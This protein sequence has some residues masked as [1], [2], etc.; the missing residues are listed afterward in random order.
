MCGMKNPFKYGVRVGGSAF[1]DR[2]KIMR[3][4][5]NTLDGGTNVLLY[6]PRRYGK[7]SLVGEIL[8]KLRA[9]GVP[10]VEL[11]MMDVASLDDFVARYAS[12]VYRELA[13]V[14]GSLKQIATLFS[15]VSPSVSLGD[16]GR[17][18]LRFSIRSAKAGIDTLRDVLELP[19]K[20][21]PAGKHAVVA[22]DEFQ[23]VANLGLGAQ[24][25]R[26]MRSAV[27]K[28]R[29]VSYVYL[30][31]KTHLLERM[32]SS[33]SRPF[34]NSA[35]KFLLQRPPLVES[36]DFVIARFA[37]A[38]LTISRELA[39][40]M[41]RRIDN[42]PYY[43]QALGSWT[44]NAAI[45]R[46]ARSV[47]AADVDEG[48]VSLYETERVYLEQ[49]FIAHPQSQRLLLRALAEESV[50]TFPEEY[51]LRHML[52]STST[53]NTALRRLIAESTIEDDEGA[54]RLAN[55][56]LAYHIIGKGVAG[57]AGERQ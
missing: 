46:N 45:G 37:D 27:E 41:V 5:C 47:S 11:N 55:P 31:S 44:F 3:G 35:Q 12:Q 43:L 21:C 53:V 20:L 38:R 34:Y 24:F 50:S 1:F 18:E 30:G 17:P 10:C 42:V 14:T 7:S 36:V 13:P 52:A 49:L 33:R 26:T 48:F 15:R 9:K 39:E 54:Y 32:F 23:E 4:I 2:T 29:H 16:D 19:E 8:E 6:G 28:Q 25:E 22:L 40:K 56:L 51:R 57:K